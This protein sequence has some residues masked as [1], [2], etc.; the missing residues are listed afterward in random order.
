MREGVEAQKK[1]E[2]IIEIGPGHDPDAMIPS[3]SKQ[4]RERMDAGALYVA[5]DGKNQL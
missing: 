5:I 3:I 1:R 4:A 2:V